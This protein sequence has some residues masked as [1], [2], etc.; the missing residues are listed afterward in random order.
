VTYDSS[1]SVSGDYEDIHNT[2]KFKTR[3]RKNVN[4]GGQVQV[5]NERE[6]RGKV[7]GSDEVVVKGSVV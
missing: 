2:H 5:L 6:L 1:G 4:R 7:E 3:V